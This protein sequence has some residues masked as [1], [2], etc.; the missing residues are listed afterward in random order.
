MHVPGHLRPD[1]DACLT[2]PEVECPRWD[3]ADRLRALKQ[4]GVLDTTPEASFDD[5]ANLAARLCDAPM[6]AVSLVDAERQWFKAEVG[7]GVRETPRPLSFCAHAMLA[8]TAMVVTDAFEDPRFADNALVTGPPHIRF[9]AGHPLKAS[10]GV[11]LG[12]L[13]VLDD[14][15]RPEG[16]TELQTMALKT[17]ADQVMTQ[18]ELRRALLDRDRS[19]DTARLAM[20]ASAYVGAW[21][22]D[23]AQNRV[24]ADERFARMYGVDAAAARDGVPIEVFTASVHPDDAVRVGE[25]IERAKSGDGVFLCEYR[26]AANGDVRWVLAR[27][28]AYFDRS[29]EAIRLPGIA[30]D[31]TERKQ[32]ETDLAETARALSES[33]TRF[34]VLADAMP[35]MV[36][37]TQPDGF[38]D[39]YNARWYEFT[40][41]PAGSTDGEGWN[42]MFHTDDQE[43]AWAAWRHSLET[44]EPYEIEYRLKHHSGVYRWTLGRAVAIRDEDGEITRWFGTCTDIDELK[45]L[46][47]GRELISQELSH[48]I[49]NIF[50]VITALVALSAR[51]YPEAKAFSASLR[52]RIAA[53]ARAHEFVRPH[54]ETSKPTVGATTL[55]SFLSDLF[56][57]YADETGA[58]R[59]RITGDDAVFD[60][61]AATSVALL[62]HELATNAAKYG[63]LS[64]KGGVVSL[65][66]V[67][68]EDRFVLTWG[69]S[70]GPTIQGEPSRTGF[71]SSLATLSVQG[72][73][74]GRLEREWRP[75]GL[76][77]VVDLPAT[78]LSRSRAA[79]GVRN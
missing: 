55:H 59:V 72:Q 49:K 78:A 46:E 9:Y 60:D 61:Q 31:I 6:A 12:A 44:G 38:H 40:G 29:G 23:I 37:S 48:R 10:D 45:R 24:V 36:W 73:L 65:V 30:V 11:S 21:D 47:Q 77:V 27:G 15:P 63:A 8:D 68:D 41:V 26:L 19:R 66:T 79:S 2:H 4:Y 62:F 57:A 33:E 50:A 20:E 56:K 22:W 1:E 7:L 34:R 58:P 69:E 64:E 51:Q 76:K 17:L 75:E 5:I 52:T 28:Q 42:D 74:G 16:L 70:G 35:Q 39:Y 54:T 18:L 14:K 53:L 32:I 67:R 25:E 3:E 13:C 71:G 43:R